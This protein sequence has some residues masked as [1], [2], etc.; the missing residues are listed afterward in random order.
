[1]NSRLR[2]PQDTYALQALASDPGRSVWVS[3]N[4][5]AGKT[6]VLAQR[7]MRLLLAG[8]DPSRI[9]CLTYT[10]AAAANMADRVFKQLSGWTMMADPE[11]A[12]AIALV[13]GRRPDGAR[14]RQARRLFA[15]A[16]ETPGG[17]KIQTIHAFCEAVLHQFALEANIPGHFELMD[18]RMEAAL[19]AEARRELITGAAE[20]RDPA[21][22]DAFA[23]VL[24]IGGEQGLDRLLGEIVAN[25]EAL[26]RFITRIIDGD[27]SFGTLYHAF[28]FEPGAS[29][30]S[31]VASVWPDS[32]FGPAVARELADCAATL[33]LRGAGE[34]AERLLAAC[35]ELTPEERLAALRA[36]FLTQKGEPR[37]SRPLGARA[38]AGLYPQLADEFERCAQ[39][40]AAVCDRLA[41][42]A[43]LDASS[44]MLKLADW[45]IERYEHLKR[46]RGL[47]DFNDLIAS[48][49]NLLARND[50]AAWVHYKL[51]KG[52]DHILLDEAQDTSPP[53]WDVVRLLAD[54][55]FAG[56][57]QERSTRTIFAVGDEKQ[58]IY[59]F[60][61][62]RPEGFYE[63][64]QA[65]RLKVRAAAGR[66]EHVRLLRSFRS[67]EDVLS[68]VD[69]VFSREEVRNGLTHDPEGVEHLPIREN[70]P[71][72]VELWPSLGPE[73]VEEPDDWTVAID[74][75]SAP[76]V[77]LAR[78]IAGTVAGWLAA[79]SDEG[80]PLSAGDILILVRKRGSFVHA[81]SREL[82]NRGIPVAGAD[83][84]TLSDHIAVRDLAAIGRFVL[85]PHDD[86]SLAALLRSPAF[87]LGEDDLYVLATSRGPGRTLFQAIR[88][89][90][91]TGPFAD[92]VGQ[93]SRWRDA[94]G[95]QR[96][97]E[98]YAGLLG[99]DRVRAEMIAR[100]GHEAGDVLDEFLSFCLAAERTGVRDLESFLALL[101]SGGPEIKRELDQARGEV[102]IMTVHA[103]KG[104]EA[105][106]VFLVDSGSAPF[107]AGHLPALMPVGLDTENGR[108]E[109]L[110]WRAGSEVMNS[111]LRALADETAR[112]AEQEY[113]RLLY[114]GMTRAMD[115]LILC[116]FHGPRGRQGA[117]WHSIAE[118][119]LQGSP[120][121]S[122]APHPAGEGEILRFR[123]SPPPARGPA[124]S[125]DAEPPARQQPALPAEL[126]AEL[127]PAP[128]LP[129][130]LSPSGAGALIEPET[131]GMASPHS[132]VLGP[133]EQPSLSIARGIAAHRLLQ[134]LPTI[135]GDRQAEAA[136]SYLSRVARDWPRGEAD[137]LL[138]SVTAILGVPAFSGLFEP[139]SRAEV[140]VMGTVRLGSRERAISGKIDR[141][142]V[143][144]GK[145]LI[146]DYK[147]NRP[148][149]ETLDEVPFGHRAQLALYR[150]ILRPVY[151][152]REVRAALVYT[153]APRLIEMPAEALDA[154]L[155]RLGAA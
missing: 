71:G 108:V 62:A 69:L 50:A 18:G 77:R 67:T 122:P 8:T 45:L 5:G 99:R 6:H 42:L 155:A 1:M 49:V 130:P 127:P 121:T 89:A 53:Q 33:G 93:L 59:S 137:A 140:S 23:T 58:S 57:G 98:F 134:V 142:A 145:V 15:E 31:V 11:L 106:L 151:P 19:V 107:H 129:R 22:A 128:R 61:G 147:T 120:H 60:Q 138:A 87:G 55:F 14:L 114:V 20:G 117:T 83:R 81:L 70:D 132:P 52:I 24:Q 39:Q 113:R 118:A 36:A 149:P 104:L 153:D 136:R 126:T 84:L 17:L 47:L 56:K 66:F 88:A 28:G 101:E 154:A 51:D 109:G 37:S 82:K 105:P 125:A 16:L 135:A 12:D 94:A 73:A 100:L 123:T 90:G 91:E 64:G 29:R 41:Q 3:A 27:G 4:A 79:G 35:G 76:A 78:Q 68:A 75:A 86:L 124:S 63:S 115:R 150:E 85:Q 46:A 96:P 133:G 10:K 21:L 131:E 13:E 34:F 26:T 65:F 25:R 116:G 72:L 9:L 43:M 48:T 38:L 141:I 148:A 146:V 7:V 152:G 102:R 111:R 103:A 110:L 40:V 32:Y 30:A 119:A 74:H 44:A 2:I 143:T 112:R 144:G 92:I 80:R 95:Y 54:E 139:G 97:F